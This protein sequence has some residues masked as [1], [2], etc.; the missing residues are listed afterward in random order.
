MGQSSALKILQR[1]HRKHP[2]RD[3]LEFSPFSNCFVLTLRA[4]DG[5]QACLNAVNAIRDAE[6]L[7]LEKFTAAAN[8]RGKQSRTPSTPYEDALYNVTC[9]QIED[10]SIDPKVHFR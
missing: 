10:G 8:D 1:S 9:A 3:R 7:K 5:N 6:G 4:G 2:E